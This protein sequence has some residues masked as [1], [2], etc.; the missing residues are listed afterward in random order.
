MDTP[1]FKEDHISQIP[2]LQLL[3]KLGYTYLSPDEA[4]E[5]RG[6]KTTHVILEKVLRT[7][8]KEINSIRVSSTKTSLF[9]DANIEA[10]ILALKDLPM[11]EGYI[12][13]CEVAYNRITLGKDLEQSIDGDKKSFTLQYIDWNPATFLTNNVFHVTEEFRVTRL[14][15]ASKEHYVPDLVLF[16]N[17]IPLCVIECKRPDM[18]EPLSQAISQHLRSQQDDGI[19][20]LYVYAQMVLSIATDTAKYATN[21]TTEEFWAI[22]DEKFETKASEQEYKAVL[23][24]LKNKPL[25]A[26][27]KNKLFADR[28][29]YVRSHFD[30]LE[31]ETIEPTK[32]DEYLYSLCRPERLMDLIFNFILFDNGEKKIARYQQYFVIKKSIE[33]IKILQPSSNSSQGEEGKTSP[34][35]RGQRDSVSYRGNLQFTGLLDEARQLRQNQTPAEETLWQLLRNKKLNGLKFRRQ[36]QIGSYI[37]DFYCHE[38]KLIVELDGEVH[39]NIEQQKHDSIRDKFLTSSGFNILRFPNEK[40]FNSIEDVLKQIAE[41]TPSF[42]SS[43]K[44]ESQPPSPLG[45]NGTNLIK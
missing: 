11:N 42:G 39:N 43:Q 6:N 36:H 33:R 10:C 35:G 19:R 38:K 15:R 26:V 29:R 4:L 1:S 31:A 18:K 13:A 23:Q 12:A 2:A 16:V 27:Q 45:S 7:Q 22:W 25:T 17:G 9:T 20:S 21:G 41:Y 24:E 5:L 40:V 32:Q 3:Q 28:F 44:D 30:A 34:N 37:T 8:L 14:G